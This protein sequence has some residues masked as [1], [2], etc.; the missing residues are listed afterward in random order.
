MKFTG[1]HPSDHVGL[2]QQI[3]WIDLKDGEEYEFELIQYFKPQPY[4]Y[5]QGGY[6]A[7]AAQ[8]KKESKNPEIEKDTIL[9]LHFPLFTL[10]N[11]MMMIPPKKRLA[12]VRKNLGENNVF[13]KFIKHNS[14]R[15][16]ILEWEAR[17]NTE[18]LRVQSNELV[19]DNDIF[20]YGDVQP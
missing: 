19:Y 18:E 6:I 8:C 1:K 11:A 7:F 15:L 17:E 20:Q 9:Q 10:Q 4:Q 13:V 16:Q 12:T 3:R 14:K 5:K 2:F